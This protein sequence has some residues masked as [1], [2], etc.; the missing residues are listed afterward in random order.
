MSR[1]ALLSGLVALVALGA[2][3]R[4]AGT[5]V[6][7]GLTNPA[8]VTTTT[9]GRVFV[10]SPGELGKAGDGVVL[11]IKDGK[12][13]PF[14]TGLDDPRGIVAWQQLLYVADKGKVWRIDPKGKAT[15][16]VEA[17]AFPAP[18]EAFADVEA[19]AFGTLYVSHP[20]KE[21]DKTGVVYRVF[22]NRKVAVLVDEKKDAALTGPTG[23]RQLD[24]YHL[25]VTTAR[26]ELL[27]VRTMDGQV[28]K[29]AGG[30]G[31]PTGVT[32]DYFGRLYV[33]EASGKVHIIPRPGE[34]AVLV[35]E[36]PSAGDLALSRDGRTLLVTDPKGGAVHRLPCT[37]P[38]QEVD[39]GKLPVK[40]EPAFA[41]LEWTG[42]QGVTDSGKVVPHRPIALT[43]AGDGSGRVFVA[44]Q[45]GVI[46]TFANDPKAK[47]TKVFLDIQSRVRYDDNQNEEGFLG[48]AFSPKYRA[49]GEFYVFYT[50][51]KERGVNIVSR[52]RV[53]KDDPDR[54]DPDS[55]EV[56]VRWKKPFWNHDGGTIV[57][58]PDGYLYL[59]H[60]DGGA[61]NDPFGNGQ[62][63]DT[64]LGKVL[65]I[66]VDRKDDGKPYGIPKDNP[67]VGK[68]GVLPEIWAYGFRNIWRMS[69]DT[70]T[71]KLWAADVGQNLWEEINLVERGGNYGWNPRE[72]F[73]PFGLRGAKVEKKDMI[74]PIWE[75]HHDIGKSI[76]GGHVY[77]GTRVKALEGMYVYADYVTGHVW[78]LRYDE[79][80]KRVTAN[81]QLREGGFPVFSFGEDDRGEVYLLTSTPTG[82]GV[83]WFANAK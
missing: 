5:P 60:G 44:T 49:N 18:V 12:A 62:K 14:A 13:V 10:T 15:V 64:L 22:P 40:I 16:H 45:H 63:L 50:P 1:V 76:T 55:E 41:D 43:H 33:A 69:F 28:T 17:K 61:A 19:D 57:F 26:G 70:K 25:T 21:A 67:F 24:E 51:K 59:T 34:A 74:D 58:G 39:E 48:L 3:A 30:L 27:H 8:S 73:H 71:G 9:D 4:K 37:V 77:R 42:W 31:S 81:H 20:G 2:S 23:L 7:S 79:A 56:L 83:F 6:V 82:K 68:D 36:L 54:A 66:D 75:Y 29:L 38:G 72:G 35:S 47:K 46:H 32:G 65:R 80:K 53:S 78:A 52:F 11:Q